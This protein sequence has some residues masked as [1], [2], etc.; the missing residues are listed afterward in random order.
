MKKSKKRLAALAMSVMMAAST[1]VFPA[2]A[3]EPANG[4]QPLDA[5]V[6]YRVDPSSIKFHWGD[7]KDFVVTYTEVAQDGSG[8][9]YNAET[10]ATILK[11]TEPTCTEPGYLWMTVTIDGTV[12]NSGNTEL[13]ETAFVTDEALGHDWEIR[14]NEG[15]VVEFPNCTDEGYGYYYQVCKR[16][17][18][19][20]TSNI[21]YKLEAQGHSFGEN[22]TRYEKL[23]NVQ[24]V[25]GQL[26]LIDPLQDG[27]YDEVTYH[28]CE[29]YDQKNNKTC[30]YEE[31]VERENK[32]IL[33]KKVSYS[34]VTAQEGLGASVNL[35]GM[36]V[37]QVPAVDQIELADCSKAGR[38]QVTTYAVGADGTSPVPVSQRWVT[39][40]AHHMTTGVAI[41]FES[42]ED[43][44]LCHVDA[45]GNVKNNSC[46]KSV[47][48]YEVI[49]CTAAGCPNA[50]CDTDKYTCDN[51]D[52]TEVSR[53]TKVAAPEGAHII[54]TDIEAKVKAEASKT[55]AD[56]N[57][58][59][60]LAA[61]ND[62]YIVLSDNS[63][64]CTADGTATV[65]FLCKTC[66]AEVSKITV[67]TEKLGHH[68]AAPVE[69]NVVEATCQATGSYDAVIYCDRE[70]CG[71]ELERR[72]VKT[73]RLKHTNEVSVTPSGV[74]KDDTET[75]TTAYI[76]FIGD[77]V[78]DNNGESLELVGQTLDRNWVGGYFGTTNKAEFGV[79]AG[80]YTNCANCND[81]EVA[82][83]TFDDVKFTIVSVEKQKESG[84]A[85]K[86][87]L[88]ASY[89][90][91][92]GETITEEYSN[93]PYFTTIEAYMGRVEDA[94]LN[95]LHLDS[96][97]VFR[98]YEDDEFKSDFAGIVEY[99]GERFFV[100]NGVLASNGNGLNLYDGEWY[101]L[102]E[103]R[104]VSDYNGLALYDGEWFYISNGKLDTNVNG[105]VPYD[106]GLFV[107]AEGRK[108]AELNGL[109]QDSADET[110]YF[111]AL[112]QVQT[113]HTG[114]A[115]YDGAFFYVID[116]KLAS[117]YNG[118]IEYDG[119]VFNVV[120]GQLYDQVA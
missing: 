51:K 5:S 49:H 44:A 97:G 39:V 13:P 76:K 82:L 72:P 28:V 93:I 61:Q 106:G 45:N 108:C 118:T 52:K 84:E 59:K 95:G 37:E 80:V 77:K 90:K 88:L 22:Q 25:D 58:L 117:D 21:Q 83:D 9:S 67:N 96:D 8:T 42:A 18:K 74:G 38:Y 17:Q 14:D 92:N 64:T 87:T 6:A 20:E 47:T 11:E 40:P 98:Y 113:Q 78:V 68:A 99:Y 16:C 32:T 2:Y 69:E 75:D 24:L 57:Y 10:T 19:E 103:G 35:I 115:M 63:A 66:K 29:R 56:Y 23:N 81:H 27:T 71:V 110:W 91:L 55:Y 36:R 3:E 48:Y 12:Y 109:W 73:P 62:N 43:A 54:N 112:G 34:E 120:A 89:T 79:Q 31:V 53:E 33:A 94:P 1:M 15:Y 7:G 46:W 86:I 65:T 111:T 50:K 4:I 119:A 100:A 102:S 85:G 101:F 114:V 26:E 41:E 116:G 70:G 60:E 107:F 104:I 30:G 105:L